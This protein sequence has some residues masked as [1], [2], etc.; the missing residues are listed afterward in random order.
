MKKAA[1]F[2]MDGVLVD[3]VALNWQ[4]NNQALAPYGIHVEDSQLKRYV[5]RTLKDQVQQ[6][7]TDYGVQL[8]YETFNTEATVIKFRL[9]AHLTPKE[10]VIDLLQLLKSQGI[11]LG[12]ATSNSR[13]NTEHRLGGAGLLDFFDVVVTE[14]DVTTHKP[15][16]EVYLKTAEL[17]GVKPD[18]CLVFEDAPS[19]VASAKAAYMGCIAVRTTQ[20]KDADIASADKIVDSLAEV[21]QSV[22]DEIFTRSL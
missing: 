13:E 8:D 3:T 14:D 2:D 10:G 16:P 7:S 12:V 21:D 1:I 9:M 6:L 20:V 5:G 19:G 22:I 18:D 15:D 17:L 11:P 4:A